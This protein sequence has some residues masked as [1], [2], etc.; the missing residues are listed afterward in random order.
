M[1]KIRAAAQLDP[2]AQLVVDLVERFGFAWVVDTDY[3]TPP[4]PKSNRLQIRDEKHYTP[5]AEVNRYATAM[6]DGHRFPPIVISAD[7]LLVDGNTRVQAALQNKFPTLETVILRDPWATASAEVQSRMRL[8]GAAGNIKNGRG[9]DKAEIA[10]AVGVYAERG[11][12]DGARIS[13]LLGVTRSL[14]DSILAEQ[15]ART[16]AER[17]GINLNG[18]TPA[19]V[20]R[21]LG[22]ATLNDEPFRALLSLIVE[23]GM[24]SPEVQAILKQI[25]DSPERN[26]D[27]F[28]A[29]ITAER[30]SRED[31][32][33]D[34]RFR[35]K[36]KPPASAKLRQSLGFL[37]GQDDPTVMVERNPLLVADHLATVERAVRALE[38]VAA[39]QRGVDHG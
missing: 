27:A 7:G 11:D 33:R 16:R 21:R 35:G 9:I 24:S 15:R 13:K 34:Y 22:Q 17:F 14:V 23:S 31:Q 25:K 3:P 5:Q 1:A 4:D 38:Q 28:L 19:T 37:L 36:A 10:K 30:T 12:L 18:S 26:D 20:L 29:I 39:A 8:L 2:E 32:I 6:R